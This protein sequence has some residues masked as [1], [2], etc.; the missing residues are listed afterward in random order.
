MGK[1]ALRSTAHSHSG[2]YERAVV[3]GLVSHG[4][5]P[6]QRHELFTLPYSYPVA[7]FLS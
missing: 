2:K 3:E 7:P 1:Y 6:S 5:R 4:E